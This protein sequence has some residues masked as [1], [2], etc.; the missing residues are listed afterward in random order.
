M[1][2]VITFNKTNMAHW[3]FM[4]NSARNKIVD[5]ESKE[6]IIFELNETILPLNVKSWHIVSLACLLE[7]AS[8]RFPNV[9]IVASNELIHFFQADLSLDKYFNGISHIESQSK[10]ILNL[11]KVNSNESLMYSSQLSEYLKQ[12]YFQGKDISMVKLM[13]DELYA[14]IAD[15]SQSE[16]IAYS[17]VQYY[18]ERE[19]ISVAFCDFGVGIPASLKHHDKHPRERKEYIRY[20]TQRGITVNSNSHNAGFGLATVLDCM[21]GSNHYLR[22]I[23]NDELYYHLNVNNS[24]YEKTYSLNQLF[25]GTLIY[26]DLDISQF[27]SEEILGCGDLIN[28]LDW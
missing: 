3:L 9:S 16:D 15:H 1:C 12:M 23:S 4:L 28:E 10:T 14:N 24:I 21:E 25:N 13:L 20:A 2:L 7:L 18:P 8:K 11:W 17:Y 22:I 27:Q 6:K 5:A 26:Y 19:V